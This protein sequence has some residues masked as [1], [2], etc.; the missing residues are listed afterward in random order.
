MC[1]CVM[2]TTRVTATKNEQNETN[3]LITHHHQN[4]AAITIIMFNNGTRPES[5]KE[6]VKSVEEKKSEIR[7]IDLFFVSSSSSSKT[8]ANFAFEAFSKRKC[9]SS[10]S[11]ARNSAR[12]LACSN[13]DSKPSHLAII[14]SC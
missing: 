4:R 12:Q 11:C 7:L 14:W 8:Y 2:K 13:C 1:V 5:N 9:C 10:T 6:N 3:R